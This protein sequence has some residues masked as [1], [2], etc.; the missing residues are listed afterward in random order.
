MLS[1]IDPS[2]S[3]M[4]QS[5]TGNWVSPP[6]VLRVGIMCPGTTFPAWQ[7]MAIKHLVANPGVEIALLI[8]D[9]NATRSSQRSDDIQERPLRVRLAQ[10]VRDR[11]VLRKLYGRLTWF[12]LRPLLRTY[13]FWQGVSFFR[14]YW[15]RTIRMMP[16]E[17]PVDLS[18]L[19]TGVPVI[20]CRTER[21]GRFSQYFFPA[22]LDAIKQYDLDLILRFGFNIIRGAILTLPRYGV[23]SYHHD[24]H[25][26]YRGIPAGFWEIYYG[27]TWNGAMLQRLT[28]K[29]DDGVIIRKEYFRTIQHSYAQNLNHLYMESAKWPAQACQA[30]L[31]GFAP[32]LFREP[33]RSRAPI[34]KVPSNRQMVWYLAKLAMYKVQHHY[35]DLFGTSPVGEGNW[36]IGVIR[37]PVDSLLPWNIPPQV[38]WLVPPPGRFFADPFLIRKDHIYYIFFEDFNYRTDKGHIGVIETRDWLNFSEPRVVLERPYHLSYPC[39]FEHDGRFYC[40]PE[41]Y[42]SREVVLYEA[43]QFPDRWVPRTVLLQDFAGVDPTLLQHEG[44]WWLFLTNQDTG[45]A[46]NL[47]LFYADSLFGPWRAHARN[48]VR[49][50]LGKVRPAG[51]PFLLDGRLLRPSQNCSRTYGESLILN[52]ITA[53]SPSEFEERPVIELEAK[54]DWPYAERLHTLCALGDVTL[55]DAMRRL[56]V[57]NDVRQ[58]LAMKARAVRQRLAYSF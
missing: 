25:L 20:G 33:A 12:F 5:Q 19:L 28:D 1:I 30:L 9:R 27:D 13:R 6:A 48:P 43:E 15:R 50:E 38:Q 46:D 56:E 54:A 47:Y 10:A 8:V 16:C 4:H 49:R 53:L 40:T 37:K 55:I 51:R 44:R 22:D 52:H 42:Q 39:V 3:V 2:H 32:G 58:V 24:D 23:W 31:Q 18:E 7:A 34:Y 26:R 14:R 36:A 11:E 41:Q 29:L 57:R 17:E 35:Q 21:R 45:Y